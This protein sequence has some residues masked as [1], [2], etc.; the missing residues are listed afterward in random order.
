MQNLTTRQSSRETV[1]TISSKG[2]VTLPVKVRIH[3]GVK[4]NGQVAFVIEPSG[5]VKVTHV[6]Y[7]DIQSLRGVAGTLK[8]HLSFKEMRAIAREDRLT[9]KY[10]K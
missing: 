3:L 5:D 7:P 8:Q 10:G 2:Q 1:S 6:K 4:P 9:N